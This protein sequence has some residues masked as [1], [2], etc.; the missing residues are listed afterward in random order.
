MSR[1]NS[2]SP[3]DVYTTLLFISVGALLMGCVFLILELNSYGW[4]VGG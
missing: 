2:D 1:Q 4:Q 3:T